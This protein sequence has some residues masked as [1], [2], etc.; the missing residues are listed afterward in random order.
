MLIKQRIKAPGNKLLVADLHHIFNAA[1]ILL[2]YR[3][4]FVNARTKD[5][6]YLNFAK[7]VF[8]EETKS[9]SEY[10]KDCLAVLVDMDSMVEGLREIIHWSEWTPPGR[11]NEA[12]SSSTSPSAVSGSWSGQAPTGPTEQGSEEDSD[13]KQRLQRLMS[14]Q[15]NNPWQEEVEHVYNQHAVSA[16]A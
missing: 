15:D 8:E 4:S 1:I 14:W 7:E 2:M 11:Q 13:L 10:A 5:P 12:W 9:G 6:V 3:I 16:P